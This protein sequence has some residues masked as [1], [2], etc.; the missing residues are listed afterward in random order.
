M[1]LAVERDMK[2]DLPRVNVQIYHK[3]KVFRTC[4][5][6]HEYTEVSVILLLNI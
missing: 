6:D 2:T 4:Q 5:N 1:T 3:D